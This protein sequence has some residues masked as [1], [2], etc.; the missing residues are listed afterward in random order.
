MGRGTLSHMEKRIIVANWKMGPDSYEQAEKI[1]AEIKADAVALRG[2]VTVVCPPAVF[3]RDL[4]LKFTGKGASRIA[5]GAQTVFPGAGLAHTGEL[6]PAMLHDVGA[7]YVIVGHSERRALGE[8]DSFVAEKLSAVLKAGLFAILCVGEGRR[9]EHGNYFQVLEEQLRRNIP[10]IPKR[11]MEKL[12]IAYEPLW[13]IGENAIHPA[14]PEEV[15][16]TVIFIRKVLTERF[17]K[18][19]AM[20]VPVLYGGSVDPETAPRM[21]DAGG[22]QGLLV[23]RESLQPKHFISILRSAKLKK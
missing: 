4:S 13:A 11:Q 19:F 9:D 15:F 20:S 21:L 23:G 22:V 16:G 12:V 6:S 3:L 18:S 14:T 2:A 7:E 1:L 8:S 5:F 10:D 17:G